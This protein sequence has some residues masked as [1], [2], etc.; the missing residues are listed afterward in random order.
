MVIFI[1]AGARPK[2]RS[3]LIGNR[4]GLDPEREW[5]TQGKAQLGKTERQKV[6][7]RQS[8]GRHSILETEE[9][10]IQCGLIIKPVKTFQ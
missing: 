4:T 1:L 2:L 5:G 6:K 3:C 9:E 10:V 7:L 8:P